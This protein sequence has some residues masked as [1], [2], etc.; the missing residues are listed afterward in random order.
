MYASFPSTNNEQTF[1]RVG[2]WKFGDNNLISVS[3]IY[4]IHIYNKAI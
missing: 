3:I 2:R 4:A 1:V